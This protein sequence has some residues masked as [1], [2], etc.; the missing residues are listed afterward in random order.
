MRWRR[1]PQLTIRLVC[2]ENGRDGIEM[3]LDDEIVAQRDPNGIWFLAENVTV[4]HSQVAY[5]SLP[6][7]LK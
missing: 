1:K 4:E 2:D 7:G 3:R 5:H 6:H